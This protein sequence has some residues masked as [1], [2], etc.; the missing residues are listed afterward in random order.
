V[1]IEQVV[2][3]RKIYDA[4]STN[5]LRLPPLVRDLEIDYTGL[6]FIAPEKMRFRYKLEGH[7]ADWQEAGNRR[8][9]FYNNLRPRSY[10]F[11][12]IASNNSGVWNEAGAFLDFSVAPAYYQA[13]WFRL[14][15]AGA[16]LVLLAAFY[17][18]RLQYLKQQFALRMEER[19]NERT[20]IARDLHDTLLQSLAGVSLQLDGIA[21]QSVTHPEKTPSMIRRIREQVDYAFR[22]ARVKVWNLRSPALEGQ[23][24]TEALHQLVERI[25]P[26]LE[27]RCPVTVSGEPVC[28]SPE[29]EE[30]LLHIAQEAINNAN[31]HARAQEIR[32]T[33]EYCRKSVT[34]SV[35]DDGRGF[36]FA[37]GYGKSGHWGLK[38]ME[39]RAA[40]IRGACTIT[41]APGKGTQIQICVPLSS[42]SLRNIFAKH[43]H[44]NSP[45]R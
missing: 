19:V 22:E 18:L 37:E 35:S 34:L 26:A 31:R 43:A 17:L 4:A 30:E 10:R 24:L 21:K 36:D 23:G 11:R 45:S 20:R 15:I 39:E 28:C 42:R 25:G 5:N 27:A 1:H 40:Q 38:N 41:T 14:S 6:S 32:V 8:Q 7:D 2:A 33:L 16:V 29:V 13:T 3:D 9:A 12:A 44:S